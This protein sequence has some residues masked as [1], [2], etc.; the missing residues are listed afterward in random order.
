MIHPRRLFAPVPPAASS[1]LVVFAVVDLTAI[2]W[3]VMRLQ[4]L[5]VV[6]GVTLEA[7]LAVGHHCVDPFRLPPVER[8]QRRQGE[9]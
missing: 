6:R 8:S 5:A 7:V 9:R 4:V 2:G 3:L 1:V